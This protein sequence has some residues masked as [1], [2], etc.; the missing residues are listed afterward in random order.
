MRVW[1]LVPVC[2]LCVAAAVLFSSETQRNTSAT[3]Y[4]EAKTAQQLLA[5][6]LNRDRALDSR[7]DTGA[8]DALEDYVEEGT[9]MESLLNRADEVSSDD[10]PELATIERQ[11]AAYREWQ[12]LA[13]RELATGSVPKGDETQRDRLLDAFGAANADYQRRLELNRDDE[14]GAAALVAVWMTL[15]VSGLF[16]IVGGLLAV[17]TRRRDRQQRDERAGVRKAEDAFRTSQVR[18]SEA[19]QVSESQSEAHRLIARHLEATISDSTAVALNRNNSADRL[20]PTIPLEPDSPLSEP[21]QQ[22]KPRSCMAVRL[23]RPYERSD[24]SEEIM[25]CEICGKLPDA[26]VCQPLLVGGEVIGSVLVGIGG[27]PTDADRR[28]V[29]ESVAQAAPVLANLRNLA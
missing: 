10:P 15:I 26:S 20:E 3:T 27:T 19:L 7:L 4:E 12:G 22:A 1:L 8:Q 11:R 23:N 6:F 2:V 14:D 29:D 5:S 18:F 17:R 28:R 21:L 25:E 9:R 16:A 13:K 24:A